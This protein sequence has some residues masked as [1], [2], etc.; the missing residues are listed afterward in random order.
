VDAGFGGMEPNFNTMAQLL[1]KPYVPS[2]SS[3]ALQQDLYTFDPYLAES[4]E[5]SD[6]GLT[7]TFSLREAVS[8]A[9]NVLSA[10]DVLWSFERKFASPASISPGLLAPSLTDPATQIVKV[11]DRTVAFTLP[12]AGLGTTFLALLSD[13]TTQIYDST[14]LKEHATA[15]D[16]YAVAWSADNPNYGFGPYEVT[17]HE[18]GS[19]TVLTAREDFV[20]GEPEVQ[21]VLINVVNDPATRAN[22]VRNGDADLA[23]AISPADLETLSSEPDVFVPT[24]DSPNTHLMMPLVTNKAPFDNVL[25]RQA[26]AYAVPYQQIID[27]VYRGRALRQGSGFLPPNAPGYDGTDLPEYDSDP[28]KA[29][30]LLAQAGLP[31][32]VE[33]TLAVS[34]ADPDTVE[35][36]VQIQTYAAE[37]GF[38]IEVDQMPAAEFGTQRV[39]HS[40]QA[41]LLRDYAITMTPPYE[42]LVYTAPGNSNN[43][44]NW[45]DASFYEALERGNQLPDALSDEAGRAWN[46]AER[47][48]LEQSPI[49]FITQVQPTVAMSEDLSGYAWRSDNFLDFSTFSF[50][51]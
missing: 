26:M 30:A 19:R 6:D 33:F 22:A 8:A 2:G 29:R 37:A 31:D 27:S 5:V 28:A 35:A 44:A 45:E 13:F 18:Q 41:F 16:P 23:E 14:L 25:V 38:T 17:S 11:D 21:T 39:D 32:G 34:A 46:A 48:Y 4:Y 40:S 10:D 47:I 15:D 51:G 50:Q 24:V 36:A 12:N 3:A 43:F 9:G 42:L 20:L 49:V 7:Y 1:R